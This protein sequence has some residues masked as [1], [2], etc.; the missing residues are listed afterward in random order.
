MFVLNNDKKLFF[1]LIVILNT[2]VNLYSECCTACSSGKSKKNQYVDN[3]KKNISDIPKSE[4][5]KKLS[6]LK[7]IQLP[8]EINQLQ[9]D[10]IIL[11]G[12]CADLLK[13]LEEENEDEG[14]IKDFPSDDEITSADINGLKQLEKHF[15]DRMSSLKAK[16]FQINNE[17]NILY[18]DIISLNEDLKKIIDDFYVNKVLG[19]GFEE[20]FNKEGITLKELRQIKEE[21]EYIV[22]NN[23]FFSYE[24]PGDG[25]AIAISY[26][27]MKEG[28]SS[29]NI[30]LTMSIFKNVIYKFLNRNQYVIL[31]NQENHVDPFN[32]EGIYHS[33]NIWDLFEDILLSDDH[34]YESFC[35][36]IKKI[37]SNSRF[38]NLFKYNFY[39]DK[40]SANHGYF[41]IEKERTKDIILLIK[42]AKKNSA[43]KSEFLKANKIILDDKTIKDDEKFLFNIKVD[44]INEQVYTKAENFNED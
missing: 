44:D 36:F 22:R 16:V 30:Y 21:L 34:F 27:K 13:L 9:K 3:N 18:K 39:N 6:N 24:I 2:N 29:E 43:E 11:K 25:D 32:R 7:K 38:S 28:F 35:S 26:D 4:K 40:L 23:I 14:E 1:T 41:N 12:R 10:V 19:T 37:D 20:Q 5:S 31:K 17:K 8:D 33:P 42:N 15:S